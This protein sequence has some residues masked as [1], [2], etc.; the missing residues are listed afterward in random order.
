M[1]T[2]GPNS[3]LGT[4]TQLRVGCQARHNPI[5]GYDFQQHLNEIDLIWEIMTITTQFLRLSTKYHVIEPD[6]NA[7]FGMSL[8]KGSSLLYY[9]YIYI[10]EK[11]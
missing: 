4:V 3:E 1:D 7:S 2:S 6:E 11:N 5:L 10:K 8:I 9:N